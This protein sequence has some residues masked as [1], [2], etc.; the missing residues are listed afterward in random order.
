MQTLDFMGAVQCCITY[1][2]RNE[3]QKIGGGLEVYIVLSAVW[4]LVVQA[5][6]GA[7]NG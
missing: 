6:L 2:L 3:R 4:R 5:F 1:P 7:V